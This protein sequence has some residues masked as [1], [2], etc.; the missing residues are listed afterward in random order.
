MN[1]LPETSRTRSFNESD[2]QS[3]GAPLMVSRAAVVHQVPT[4]ISPLLP[5][6]MSQRVASKR[7]ERQRGL[8]VLA[9]P[10]TLLSALVSSFSKTRTP[11]PSQGS[12]KYNVKAGRVLSKGPEPHN[13][14]T[15]ND[16][17]TED[18]RDCSAQRRLLFV[19]EW[20]WSLPTF[21]YIKIHLNFKRGEAT[22]KIKS[23]EHDAGA[24]STGDTGTQS[25]EWR[26]TSRGSL[27]PQKLSAHNSP[28]QGIS[29]GTEENSLGTGRWK[30]KAQT[31]RE[32]GVDTQTQ[33]SGKHKK[34]GNC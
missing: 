20:K 21:Q 4:N 33:I 24:E 15:I 11:P 32:K 22:I 30:S 1:I 9:W 17:I 6:T 34:Y 10:H 2:S 31:K 8:P 16:N 28:L 25:A 14:H 29:S 7:S 12:Y 27:K 18:V 19:I 23:T 26:W 13:R 5:T 3:I